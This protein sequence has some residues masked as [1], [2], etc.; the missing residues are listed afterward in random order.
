MK[1]HEKDVSSSL[2]LPLY[3]LP[4]DVSLVTQQQPQLEKYTKSHFV[5]YV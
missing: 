4:D 1:N 3:I 5:H 2:A